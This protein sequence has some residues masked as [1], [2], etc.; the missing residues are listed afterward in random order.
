MDI[1]AS[2]YNLFNNK[3]RDPV[4]GELSPINSIEQDGRAFRLKL[5]Y[6]L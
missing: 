4:G 6:K 1:S 3:F 5:T 2:I